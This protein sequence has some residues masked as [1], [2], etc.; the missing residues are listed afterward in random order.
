MHDK[1][2][3]DV[4]KKGYD[5]WLC[6]QGLEYRE[7]VAKSGGVHK[8]GVYHM[9]YILDGKIIAVGVVDI[10]LESLST[11]YFYYDPD[12]KKFSLGV[13]SA[14]NEIAYVKTL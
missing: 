2:E 14:L 6:T 8:M 12:Y 5:N 1:D 4:W 13:I 7:E 3:D 10:L 11:V 9:H